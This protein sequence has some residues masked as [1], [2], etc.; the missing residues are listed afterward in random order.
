MERV[1]KTETNGTSKKLH[2]THK[3]S[4][5][6]VENEEDIR[7]L[8]TDILVT[9]GHKVHSASNGID[10]LELFNQKQFD[11]VLTDLGMPVMSGWEVAN[12]I[13]KRAPEVII[14]VITGW[15]TQLDQSELDKNGVNIVVNKPFRVQHILNMV[16][17]AREIK[18]GTERDRSKIS[19][20]ETYL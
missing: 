3:E 2:D 20:P 5:L 16:Q 8:L 11:L 14:A 6:I 4:I 15:G 18:N 13:K 1:D 12:E 9:E 7:C 17:E 19:P 10:A